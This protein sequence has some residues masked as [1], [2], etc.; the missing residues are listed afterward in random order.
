M[1]KRKLVELRVA[2]LSGYFKPYTYQ[3]TQIMWRHRIWLLW[4]DHA[5]ISFKPLTIRRPKHAKT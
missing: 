4:G 1:R 3:S 5:S 2:P